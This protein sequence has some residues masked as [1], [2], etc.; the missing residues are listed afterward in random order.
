M[1]GISCLHSVVI[2]VLILSGKRREEQIQLT[3]LYMH[4]DVQEDGGRAA[5]RNEVQV[6]LTARL[7]VCLHVSGSS[8][9]RLHV[10]YTV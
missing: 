8:I 5:I 1:T 7:D 2:I 10:L 9:E 3:T 6:M 4:K